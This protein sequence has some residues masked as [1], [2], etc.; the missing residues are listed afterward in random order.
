MKQL[1]I[2]TIAAALFSAGNTTRAQG[3]APEPLNR[4]LYVAAP[5]IRNYTPYGGHGVIVFDIDDN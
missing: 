5:G 3:D 1:L 2:T 4:H